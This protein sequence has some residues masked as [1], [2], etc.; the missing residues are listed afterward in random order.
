MA[1]FRYMWIVE[2]R[3]GKW[4]YKITKGKKGPMPDN[5]GFLNLGGKK[6]AVDP[7]KFRDWTIRQG[8]LIK[9][10]KYFRVQIWKEN[11]PEPIN[12]LHVQTPDPRFTSEMIS[13]AMRAKKI[14]EVIPSEGLDLIKVVLV[15]ESMAL[16][17]VML[18]LISQV[19]IG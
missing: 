10:K 16:I 18:W 6:Y 14:R 19:K 11:D 13:T 1:G 4:Q 8:F 9:R 5:D 2:T 7:R 15:L 12:F 17:V 3:A